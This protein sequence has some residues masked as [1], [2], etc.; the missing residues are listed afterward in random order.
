MEQSD[1]YSNLQVREVK[2]AYG[3]QINQPDVTLIKIGDTSMIAEAFSV[4]AIT[5]EELVE[6]V[7][8]SFHLDKTS[9]TI[10]TIAEVEKIHK[11]ADE[12]PKRIR[13]F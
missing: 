4:H 8:E 13:I 12:H 10:L 2:G 6:K 3:L 11:A 1:K 9:L 5:P 7:A